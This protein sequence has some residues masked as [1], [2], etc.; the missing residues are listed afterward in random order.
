MKGAVLFPYL[1]FSSY[2]LLNL[3][4]V[5]HGGTKEADSADANN[6]LDPD[7]RWESRNPIITRGEKILNILSECIS[8]LRKVL[9]ISDHIPPETGK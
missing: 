5:L 6:L 8:S 3:S 4:I 2:A 9:K 1:Y 7:D